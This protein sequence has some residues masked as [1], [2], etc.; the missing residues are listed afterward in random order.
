MPSAALPRPV[1]RPRLAEV[2]PV[3]AAG[4]SRLEELDLSSYMLKGGGFAARDLRALLAAN[5]RLR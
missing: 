4:C 5:P 1:L 3:L 2:P